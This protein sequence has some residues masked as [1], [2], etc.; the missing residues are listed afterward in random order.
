ME[1]DAVRARKTHHRVN[2][3]HRQVGTESVKEFKSVMTSLRR[4]SLLVLLVAAWGA[5]CPRSARSFDQVPSVGN[6]NPPFSLTISTS[7]DTVNIGSGIE[8]KIVL[9]NT[10]NQRISFPQ[11]GY[12]WGNYKLDIRDVHGNP[13]QPK[14]QFEKRKDGKTLIRH[15][16]GSVF[17][18]DVEPGKTF[19]DFCTL[20]HDYYS[21]YEFP[22]PGKYTVQASRYEYESKTWAKSNTITL[23]VTK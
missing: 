9:T 16:G 23:I 20:G 21:D 8:L 5:A 17:R 4:V 12:C 3:G 18:I 15:F 14:P 11:L 2:K 13:V 22:Q 10:S 6:A 7:A 19:T 1:S